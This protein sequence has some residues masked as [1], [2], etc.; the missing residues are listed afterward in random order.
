MG[1]AH[2][3]GPNRM[4]FRTAPRHSDFRGNGFLGPQ[5]LPAQQKIRVLRKNRQG[6]THA[7]LYRH[8]RHALLAHVCPTGGLRTAVGCSQNDTCRRNSPRPRRLECMRGGRWSQS[9]T[10][11]AESAGASPRIA[12]PVNPGRSRMRQAGELMIDLY[13]PDPPSLCQQGGI[14]AKGPNHASKQRAIR[15]PLLSGAPSGWSIIGCSACS[16]SR[17]REQLSMHKISRG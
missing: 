2:G 10:E 9:G 1:R 17:L 11:P 12:L 7:T 15:V 4:V 5:A 3:A 13:S 8:P 14:V 6:R 16:A